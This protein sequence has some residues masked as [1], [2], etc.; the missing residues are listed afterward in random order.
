MLGLTNV[1][2]R[3][4]L[5]DVMESAVQ[6]RKLTK[7]MGNKSIVDELTVDVPSGEV[8]GLLGPNG[9]GKTTTIR[10]MVGLMTPTSGQ[11]FIEGI[12]VSHHH[13]DA[14]KHVGAIVENPEM[15]TF[16]TGYQNLMQYARMS[17]VRDK[18]QIDEI[19]QFLGLSA[20]IHR[21]VKTYSLGM[22]QRLGLAQALVHH[23]S[24]LVLDEPTNGLDPAGIRELRDH[25]RL[26]AKE[27]G[28][29]VIVS[30]HLL[31][32]MELMCDR[33]A[34]IQNGRL[35]RVDDMCQLTEG[36]EAERIVAFDVDNPL[37]ASKIIDNCNQMYHPM[38]RDGLV[39]AAVPRNDV[40]LVTKRLVES[41][42][43]I[44]GIRSITRTLED[45]FLE[46]TGGSRRDRAH[47]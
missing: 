6:L 15:Y 8:F 3:V 40:P 4:F 37:V 10:M 16:M 35:I 41:G 29:C 43:A 17:H 36:D 25:L 22:R 39:H 18:R 20:F 42:V 30:S 14:M 26:L 9:A 45:T 13:S 21:K 23:P 44:F 24:I 32:E 1:W 12:D 28:V 7:R 31:A 33:V 38:I 11:I 47:P 34:I 5:G 46:M 2:F 19:V 27:Y